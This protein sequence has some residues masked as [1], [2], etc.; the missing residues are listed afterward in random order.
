ML[1]CSNV[2]V[3]KSRDKKMIGDMAG[4]KAYGL[5]ACWVNSLAL[6]LIIILV[7]IFIVV[8]SKPTTAVAYGMHTINREY[9]N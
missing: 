8:M 9:Y 3:F 2:F 5:E 6:A 7:I 1:K 4:A